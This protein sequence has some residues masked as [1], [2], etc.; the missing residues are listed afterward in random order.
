MSENEKDL[1]DRDLKLFI[2]LSRAFHEVSEKIKKDIQS[3]G[4][5]PTEFA[6]L[7]LLYHKGDQPIQH[8]GKKI[9]LSSGSMTYVIDRLEEKQ[10]IQRKRC[11]RD[12]RVIYATITKKG[13]AFMQTI[14]P[15]HHRAIKKIFSVLD[16]K[17]KEILIGLLKKLGI[18]LAQNK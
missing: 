16:I 4:I 3:Y 9:L 8:I 10:L 17:E 11:S 2:V 15:Q 7:E 18:S 6:V 5:N 14:F 12:R 1:S 13:A